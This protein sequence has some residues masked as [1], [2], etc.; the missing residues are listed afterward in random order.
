MLL[1]RIIFC[2]FP[3]CSNQLTNCWA[4]NSKQ[5]NSGRVLAPQHQKAEQRETGLL[6]VS[7]ADRE[8]ESRG[9]CGPN[10]AVVKL[11]ILN[12]LKY[13]DVTGADL[14]G[15]L[16][17]LL[18]RMLLPHVRTAHTRQRLSF[19]EKPLPRT[20]E[21]IPACFIVL[22]RFGIANFLRLCRI[23]Q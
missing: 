15:S 13:T 20:V 16:R 4:S 21:S 5:T 17:T 12:M 6:T 23:R 1:T 9:P 11:L 10:L 8:P 2:W 3:I 18:R 14:S 19:R 7:P 22:Q